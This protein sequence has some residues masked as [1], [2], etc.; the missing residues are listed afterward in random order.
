MGAERS[1]LLYE[2]VYDTYDQAMPYQAETA[3]LLAAV[4][5]TLRQT[6]A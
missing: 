3:A 5:N 4:L 6:T 2:V 1:S